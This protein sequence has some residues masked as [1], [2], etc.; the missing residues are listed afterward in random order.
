VDR[1]RGREQNACNHAW[2]ELSSTLRD[3]CNHVLHQEIHLQ[4]VG[5]VRTPM[6][7]GID[8]GGSFFVEQVTA[9]I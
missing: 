6:I 4:S 2:E 1:K 7:R 3:A 5:V 8:R 9:S